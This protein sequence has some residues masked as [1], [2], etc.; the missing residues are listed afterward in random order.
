MAALSHSTFMNFDMKA[1]I[2]DLKAYSYNKETIYDLAITELMEKGIK[3]HCRNSEDKMR[4]LRRC[5]CNQC[6]D[7]YRR[8]EYRYYRERDYYSMPRASAGPIMIATKEVTPVETKI[9]EPKNYAVKKLVDEL[10]SQ[11]NSL[12]SK[13]AGIDSDK[14]M[15]K[16]YQGMLKTKN[17]EKLAIENKIKELSVALKKLGHKE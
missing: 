13:K 9:E 12:T 7:E 4:E 6:L 2:E 8:L 14:N 16:T 17:S 10:K 11:Q 15:I 1:A 5:G 3:M